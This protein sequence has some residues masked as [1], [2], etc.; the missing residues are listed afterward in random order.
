MYLNT[1]DLVSSSTPIF[2]LIMFNSWRGRRGRDNM[3]VGFTTTC[4]I[5]AYHH[6]SCGFEPCS[7]RG[8]LDT[9]L[10]D[11]ACQWFV[12]GRWFSSGTPVSPTNKTDRHDITEILL[13]LALNT[14]KE[15]KSILD[16]WVFN[17]HRK[18]INTSHNDTRRFYGFFM[19]IFIIYSFIL[20]LVPLLIINFK[21]TWGN[22]KIVS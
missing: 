4:A 15:K 9:T 19:F 6:E 13:K 2:Q 5:S 16:F 22:L 8:V 10:C 12:T 3:V 7:W 11:E 18:Y 14:R 17:K 1:N 21:F 20:C